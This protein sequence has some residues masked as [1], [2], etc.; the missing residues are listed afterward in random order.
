MA[1]LRILIYPD[2]QLRVQAK[3]VDF[4]ELLSNRFQ[5]FIDDLIETMR[6]EDGI[7]IAATQVGRPHQIFVVADTPEN[8]RVFVNPVLSSFSKR[9]TY[10]EEGC[11]SLPGI[12][13]QVQRPA[14]VR[15]KA[16]DRFAKPVDMKAST[17]FAKILQHEYD[18]L[19]GILFIDKAE[20]ITH[21]SIA[22]LERGKIASSRVSKERAL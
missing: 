2:P 12:F 4:K 5:T 8:V 6:V 20:R 1:L 7:G 19:Q 22:S 21:E 11:L 13:G 17:L 9:R 10:M 15:L 14:K 18:H 3:T 16:F